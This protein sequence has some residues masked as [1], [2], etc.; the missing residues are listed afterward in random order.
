MLLDVAS[1]QENRELLLQKH[2]CAL[3]SSVWKVTSHVDRRKNPSPTRS[4][5]Y[6]DSFFTSSGHHSQNSLKKP[7]RLT[8]TN[9]TQ[10]RKLLAAALDDASSRQHDD[11]ISLSNQG[12]DMPVTTDHLDVTLEFQKEESDTLS[13]FPSVINLSIHGTEPIPSSY[14]P[15]GEDG[16]LR[17]CMSVAENRFRYGWIRLHDFWLSAL[18]CH[19]IYIG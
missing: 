3:L 9:F 4:G 8:S 16:H 5:L 1:E 18:M 19:S 12:D 2:F 17:G 15:T 10:S 13:L 6:F 11:R 14:K 7:E